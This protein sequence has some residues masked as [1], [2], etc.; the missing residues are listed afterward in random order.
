LLA[1]VESELKKESIAVPSTVELAEL[2][3]EL[4]PKIFWICCKAD[5][6]APDCA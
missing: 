6:R 5:S 3:V 4:R 2:V 1:N